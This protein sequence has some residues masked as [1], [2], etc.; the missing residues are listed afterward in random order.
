MHH[1]P[2]HQGNIWRNISAASR[3]HHFSAFKWHS[4]PKS[5]LFLPLSSVFHLSLLRVHVAFSESKKLYWFFCQE[6]STVYKNLKRVVSKD[7]NLMQ[8][9][10]QKNSH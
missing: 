6:I 5:S 10:S 2:T 7:S 3:F 1:S 9:L 8:Q 4:Q